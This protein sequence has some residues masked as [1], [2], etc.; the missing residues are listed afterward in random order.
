MTHSVI[1]AALAAAVAPAGTFTA[2]YPTG[3]DSGAFYLSMGHKLMVNSD[4]YFFPVDFDVAF[5]ASSITVTNKTSGTT[6]PAGATIRLHMEEMGDRAQLNK[7]LGA[8]NEQRSTLGGSVYN[9][10]VVTRLVAS[11]NESYLDLIN[12]GAP[13]ALVTNGICLSQSLASSGALTLNGSLV[14]GGVA[15]LDQPRAVQAVSSGAA[16]AV[17]TVTGTDVYGATMVENITLN[18]TTAVLGKKAFKTV[19]G[20]TSNAAIA[21]PITVGSTDILGLPVFVPSEGFVL[22]ELQN[23][24]PRGGA[25]MYVMPFA[26]NQTD[27]LAGTNQEYI[28]P[29]TGFIT[30][31]WV[32]NQLNVATGGPVTVNVAGTPVTGLSATVADASAAGAVVSATPTTAYSA[33]TAVTLGQRITI[34]PGASFATSGAINGLL[35][36]A[37]MAGTLVAGMRT[38]GG[39]TATTADVRGTYKPSIA[40]DGSTVFHLLIGLNDRYIGARQY[41]G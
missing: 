7:P 12:L 14:S 36:F 4:A 2:A 35:E 21:N 18:G 29:C 19:T 11:A 40:C 22:A 20:I 8:P 26:I 32:V 15:T 24:K 1:S 37:G 3:K 9:A 23:G 27:T 31:L 30:R 41:A 6:W 38:G 17:L 34:V 13:A 5:G 25:S 10:D 16:T 39:S 28:A 33:T